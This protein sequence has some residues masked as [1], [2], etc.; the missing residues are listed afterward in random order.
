M[1]GQE[2]AKLFGG[3]YYAAR[4]ASLG[5]AMAEMKKKKKKIKTPTRQWHK[6]ARLLAVPVQRS[7]MES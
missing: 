3:G 4:F 6:E 7:L 5:E 2:G 1:R